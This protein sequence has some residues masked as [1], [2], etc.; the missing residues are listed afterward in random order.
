[1]TGVTGTGA[2]SIINK[3]NKQRKYLIRKF[4]EGVF[5]LVACVTGLSYRLSASFKNQ[6][7]RVMTIYI[8]I[9]QPGDMG[10]KPIIAKTENTQRHFIWV[11]FM[12][13]LSKL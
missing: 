5:M 12:V 9:K 8:P 3:V 1:M 6:F 13:I 2:I 7:G 10:P 11:L 4:F